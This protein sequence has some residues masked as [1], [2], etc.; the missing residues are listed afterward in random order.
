M[1]LLVFLLAL[2]ATASARAE[3]LILALSQETVEIS[4]NF[5]GTRLVLFGSIERDAQTVPRPRGYDVVVV[6]RGPL[7]DVV[8]RRKERILGVWINRDSR[9]Y[10]RV[11]SFY[12][13]LSSV[14]LEEIASE[15]V[16]A[17]LQIGL[18]NIVLETPEHPGGDQ[19]GEDDFADAFRRL[20]QDV[21]LYYENAEAVEELSRSLFK[22]QVPLPANVP[23]GEFTAE[24]HLFA[25]GTLLTTETATIRVDKTGFEQL[26]FD[27]AHQRPLVYGGM[28][29]LL[30]FFIGWLATIIFRRE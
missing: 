24:V 6:L 27:L 10:V 3:D 9:R 12:A 13:V 5:S 4:S 20:K 16:L 7:E 21:S 22:A 11:P 8:T 14:P 23:V 17:R 19:P 30:A 28:T 18:D 1:K 15:S 25:S 2:L 26:L 29:I